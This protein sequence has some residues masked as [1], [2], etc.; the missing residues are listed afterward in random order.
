MNNDQATRRRLLDGDMTDQFGADYF[1]E[2]GR[3]MRTDTDPMPH[4]VLTGTAA[5][6]KTTIHVVDVT[7]L[8]PTDDDPVER[9]FLWIAMTG[10]FDLYPSRRIGRTV[11][12]CSI[13]GGHRVAKSTISAQDALNRARRELAAPP[14]P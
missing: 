3:L 4:V 2:L 7:V 13:A 10:T 6:G 1:A 12:P 11:K 5:D 8:G 14:T 9:G